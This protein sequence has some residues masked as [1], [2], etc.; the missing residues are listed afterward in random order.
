M[1]QSSD[2][3]SRAGPIRAVDCILAV[4]QDAFGDPHLCGRDVGNPFL[5]DPADP[6]G[7]KLW[8]TDPEGRVSSERNG[9][10]FQ[11]VVE[12]GEYVPGELHLQ[13][14]ES[15]QLSTGEQTFTDLSDI[16]IFLKCEGGSRTASESLA[17][18]A[19]LI[20]KLFRIEI[21]REFDLQD[22]KLVSIGVPSVGP[23]PGL[24][25][26]TT[27]TCRIKIQE[28]AR[29]SQLS[30]QLNR[31]ALRAATPSSEAVRVLESLPPPG[32][33]AAT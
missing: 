26:V 20:L 22:L 31:L 21:K 10:R 16:A 29:A 19:Y 8:I 28:H 17:W 2:I 4:L 12:R 3:R 24:P 13:N 1:I 18:A 7:S 6:K 27:V 9:S 32:A 5:F 33:V 15:A 25:W 11:L 14:F 30:N 23:G